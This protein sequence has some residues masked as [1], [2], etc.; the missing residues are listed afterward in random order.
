MQV[1]PHGEGHSRFVWIHDVQPDD[2][3][4]PM[5]AAMRHGLTI[6]KQTMETRR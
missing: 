3:A 1:F 5:G 4:V 2:L 6:F